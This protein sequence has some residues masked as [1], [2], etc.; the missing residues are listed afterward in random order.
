MT[1]IEEGY[2]LAKDRPSN[3]NEHIPILADYTSKCASVCEMGLNEM[4]TTWAFLKG[5]RFNKKKKK[6]WVGVD[7]SGKPQVYENVK[8]IAKRN[9]I[10][11]D[12]VQGDSSLVDIPNVDLL[13]IDTIHM[14]GLLKRELEKHHNIVN[15]YIIIHNTF[16]DA[17]FSEIVRMCFY[18]HNNVKDIMKHYSFSNDEVCKGLKQAIVDFLEEHPEW[19]ID[20]QLPNNNGLTVLARKGT[21]S[22]DEEVDETDL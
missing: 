8:D 4:T 6:H 19:Q 3:V 17:E 7:I 20:K 9:S 5:L 10:V 1:T 11:M 15:K 16:V 21:M 14:Y 12:F 2:N 18:K 22:I 13:F